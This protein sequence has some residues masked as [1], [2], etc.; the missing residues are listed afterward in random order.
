[1]FSGSFSEMNFAECT[2]MTATGSF[3]KRS[4]I[5]RST[6]RTCMQLMQQ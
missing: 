3:A 6:G 2:P 5:R 4:S 1:M